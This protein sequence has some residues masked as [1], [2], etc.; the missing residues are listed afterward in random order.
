[1]CLD[2]V[3]DRE[4]KRIKSQDL[5]F[6]RVDTEDR[7]TTPYSPTLHSQTPSTNVFYAIDDG[8]NRVLSV[9]IAG[10]EDNINAGDTAQID[11][12]RA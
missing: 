1:M 12:D 8:F 6:P 4:C 5:A 11:S 10:I 7:C 2:A 3:G 9:D